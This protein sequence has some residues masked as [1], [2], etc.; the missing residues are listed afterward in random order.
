MRNDLC[1]RA[2][3]LVYDCLK[4]GD[5]YYEASYNHL[6]G[7]I[8]IQD[9]LHT[10]NQRVCSSTHFNV[11]VREGL[12]RSVYHNFRGASYSVD[13]AGIS[14]TTSPQSLQKQVY[15]TKISNLERILL[16]TVNFLIAVR[17]PLDRGYFL[18]DAS[19]SSNQRC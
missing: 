17:L 7:S 11:L 2:F 9:P 5:A 18:Q 6:P 1:R 10:G 12:H 4:S 19:S 14:L 3:C 13:S 15:E 8:I 16:E